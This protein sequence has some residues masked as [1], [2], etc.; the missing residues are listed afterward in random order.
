MKNV[1]LYCC[2]FTLSACQTLHGHIGQGVGTVLDSAKASFENSFCKTSGHLYGTHNYYDCV[3][4]Y[5]AEETA[6]R[7]CA[8]HFN[9]TRESAPQQECVE[10]TVP[11]ILKKFDNDQSICTTQAESAN[12]VQSLHPLSSYRVFWHDPKTRDNHTGIM[13]DPKEIETLLKRQQRHY[14]LQCLQD[15]GWKPHFTLLDSDGDGFHTSFNG[16][17]WSH[18]S[19]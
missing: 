7:Y 1:L 5:K 16:L 14:I 18:P 8:T 10:I 9:F 4:R 17:D 6:Y 3:K 19:L 2:L 11:A 15:Q 12:Y 13:I